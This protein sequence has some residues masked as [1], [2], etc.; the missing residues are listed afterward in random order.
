M[1]SIYDL[2][3]TD[4]AAEVNGV[5][6]NYGEYGKFLIA[7]SGGAN[8]RYLANML[9]KTKQYRKQLQVQANSPDVNTITL[10]R[11]IN[12]QLMAECVLLGWEDV[13]GKDGVP[14][15]FSKEAALKLLNDLPDLY[16]GLQA[17][18]ADAGTFKAAELEA[19]AKN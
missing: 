19:A 13:I 12:I 14:M 3:D 10:M 4:T 18:S 7:R 8:T 11:N 9:A 6:V 2:F 5:W 16:D 15:P 17:A 1:K